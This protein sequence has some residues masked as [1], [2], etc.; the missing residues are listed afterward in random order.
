MTMQTTTGTLAESLEVAIPFADDEDRRL[1]RTVTRLLGDGEPVEDD[2][3][4]AAL[5]RPDGAVR[6]RLSRLPG[7][8]RDDRERIVGFWGLSVVETPH[9]LHVDGLELYAWC[10]VDSLFQPIVLGREAHVESTCPTT[11]ARI[12]LT[13][14]RDGLSGLRPAGAVTSFLPPGDDG[15]SGDVIRRFCHFIH[16]FASEDAAQLWTAY[17]DGTFVLSVEDAFELARFWAARA[18]G[19]ES[20]DEAGN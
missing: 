12:T 5:D 20:E 6:E 3:L 9:R 13:V 10:A 7:V 18:Y 15:F 16:F 2:R 1:A 19:V 11:G 14:S 4:A 8:Y 17:H